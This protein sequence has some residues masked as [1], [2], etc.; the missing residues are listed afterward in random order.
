IRRQQCGPE[1]SALSQHRGTRTSPTDLLSV[2]A[3]SNALL[4]LHRVACRTRIM[5]LLASTAVID[6]QQIILGRVEGVELR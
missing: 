1:T 6:A 2:T 3:L 4:T 5:S